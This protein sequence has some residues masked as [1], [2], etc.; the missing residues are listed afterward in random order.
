MKILM[1]GWEFPPFFAGG[2]GIVCYELTKALST[3]EDIEITYIMPFGPK[4]SSPTEQTKHLKLLIANGQGF[5]QNINIKIETIDTIFRAYMTPEEYMKAYEENISS[6]NDKAIDLYGKNLYLEVERYAQKVREIVKGQKFDAIHA[7]DWMTIPA[8]IAAKDEIGAPL[9]YH[10]HNTVYDRYLNASCS[11]EKAIETAG[12]KNANLIIAI[13]NKIKKTLLEKYN[14][15]ENKIRIVH[16]GGITDIKK[17]FTDYKIST[18]E[19]KFVLFAGRTVLQKGPEYFIRTAAKVLEYEP[20]TKFIVAGSGHMLPQCIELS[21]QLGISKNIYFH[22]FYTRQ[23]ADKFYTMADVFVMP[24]ISEPFGIVPLEAISKGT[25]TIISKQS[26]ISECLHNCFKVDFW[27]TDETAN[28]IISLLRY[29]PL[30]THMR[31]SAYEEF[32]N[33]TWEK[34]AQNIINIYQEAIQNYK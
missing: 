12:C 14:A 21:A 6:K 24:S 28:K 33:F 34:P 23:E 5:E 7:H 2:V 30:H 1:L 10:V 31:H 20:D 17:Y 29:E 13:S 18:K 11:H 32:D 16:N 22:G 3:R 19:E 25:A 4:D 8:G 27:D 9:I 15:D 26:G